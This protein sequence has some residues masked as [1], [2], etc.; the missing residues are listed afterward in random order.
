MVFK[1]VGYV[2]H[3]DWSINPQK[4]WM[5]SASLQSDH[6]WH[7]FPL[8]QIAEPGTFLDL[9]KSQSSTSACILAGFDFPIGLPV[10]Y[11]SKAGIS[12]FLAALSLFG[13]E[14]WDQFFQPAETPVQISLHRP[15]YPLRPG[16]AR[17]SHLEQG[18]I[19]G[20][21]Q[22]Y[23][24]CELAHKNRPAACPLFWTLGSQ[25]VGKAAIHGWK[26][27][28][29]TALLHPDLCVKIWPFSGVLADICQPGNLVI[30]E[31]YPAEF[32]GQLGILNVKGITSKRSLPARQHYATKLISWAEKL[33][34]DLENS[35][36]ESLL[37]GFGDHPFSEDQFDAL[38]GLYGMINVLGGNQPS[39][40]PFPPQVS[41]IEGWIFGQEQPG[42]D[43]YF[44]RTF[45]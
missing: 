3:S 22:L 9:I 1:A 11:A 24:L 18:L 32:Y 14:E 6:R 12:N 31:T 40:E 23:R 5:A 2:C 36:R 16:S 44:A 25:Q 39:G 35:L 17:R 28:L 20:F 41:N 13:R 37:A 26:Q 4:R 34:I 30:V 33:D 10:H 38:I 8:Q 7:A 45:P 27:L 29:S 15:F 19:L 42:S 43:L 21:Q